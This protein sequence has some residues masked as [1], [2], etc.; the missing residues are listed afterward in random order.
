[1]SNPPRSFYTILSRKPVLG[2]L[3]HLVDGDL[4]PRIDGLPD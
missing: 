1:M 4:E 2:G 3:A